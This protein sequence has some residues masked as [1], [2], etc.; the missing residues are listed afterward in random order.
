MPSFR[1]PVALAAAFALLAGCSHSRSDAPA[2]A[3]SGA[4][5]VPETAPVATLSAAAL[6]T[7]LDALY[8]GLKANHY[9]LYARRPQAEYDAEVA[10][11]REAIR[12]PLSP[13]QARLLFQRVLAFGNI[14]HANTNL[15]VESWQAFQAAG[16]RY[17]PLRIRVD[18]GRALLLESF[19]ETPAL[20]PGSEILAVDGQP[21]LAWLAEPRAL[22]SADNDYFAYALLEDS[23][24]ELLFYLHGES[25]THTVRIAGGSQ[26]RELRVSG[27]TR[28][29]QDAARARTPT[30]ARRGRE[31]RRLDDTVAYLRPGPFYDD[32][33]GV[34]HPW[35]VTAFA[36]FL[37]TA[38]ADLAAAPTA[39]LIIDLRD[40]PGGDSSFSDLLLQR[41]AREPFAFARSV[42][43]R[44]GPAT[45]ASSRQRLARA[46]DN[47]NVVRIATLLESAPLGALVSL[48]VETVPPLIAARYDGAVYALINRHSYSNTVF[49]AA[50]LQDYGLAT[51]LGEETADLASTYGAMEH[52][53]LPASGIEVR[54]PKAKILRPSGVMDARGVVPDIV[55]PAPPGDA[56]D[57]VLDA[58]VKLAH[59]R[60]RVPAER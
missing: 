29:E 17:F 57:A 30:T 5:T 11:V 54:Y 48:P 56:E 3:A 27:V 14:A 38:F 37:D 40:N 53:T 19:A 31:F 7:D 41:I 9:D 35:D 1:L 22:L 10:R 8:A 12:S 34:E 55:L 18:G 36:Q 43:I 16:G 60:L 25:G 47:S 52:F 42:E 50:T 32:R 15:P 26:V 44:V 28:A 20:R 45:L 4:A 39:A 33:P 24:A 13:D 2:A 6:R 23:L 46:P 49:V 58:A 21:V 51:L 59:E